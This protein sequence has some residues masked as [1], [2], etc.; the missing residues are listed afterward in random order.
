M[1]FSYQ[2]TDDQLSNVAIVTITVTPVN[3]PPVAVD[4]GSTVDEGGVFDSVVN[5]LTVF[6][7]ADSGLDNDTDPED[8]L[9]SA[10]PADGPAHGILDL[11]DNGTFTYTHDGGETVSDSFTY[12]ANDGECD[13]DA[14]ATVNITIN[15]V[16]DPPIAVD[17]G[18]SG[19]YA[20]D[21]NTVLEIPGGGAAVAGIGHGYGANYIIDVWIDS[22]YGFVG[23]DQIVATD[24]GHFS[25]DD[26]RGASVAGEGTTDVYFTSFDFTLGGVTWDSNTCQNGNQPNGPVSCTARINDYSGEVLSLEYEDL[27]DGYILYLGRSEQPGEA[28]HF[29][30]YPYYSEFASTEGDSPVTEG[31]YWWRKAY[32]YGIDAFVD[33][34]NGESAGETGL[35]SGAGGFSLDES[36]AASVEGTNETSIVWISSF[37]FTLGDVTWDQH[38]YFPNEDH[39]APFALVDL[40][41]QEILGIEIWANEGGPPNTLGGYGGGTFLIISL[42]GSFRIGN[43][44]ERPLEASVLSA[45]P[46]GPGGGA[47][48]LV[49]GGVA[50][51]STEVTGVL[52][53]DFD[54]ENDLL[55]VNVGLTDTE[56]ALGAYVDVNTDGSFEYDPTVSDTLQGLSDGE[57]RVDTFTYWINDPSGESDSATVSIMVSGISDPPELTAIPDQIRA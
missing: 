11:M 29:E 31:Y 18:P 4:D 16:N 13:S 54:A 9:L 6:A 27:A 37:S 48:P 42:D 46:S 14:T 34:D 32:D 43:Q 53:N 33:S 36:D 44:G 12:Y 57:S 35:F 1:S 40:V 30:I 49:S 52:D 55:V 15:P 25:V 26:Y 3:D 21:E 7:G 50:L 47:D 24:V 10:V 45:E 39:S 22:D 28:D 51:T 38:S 5:P 17:D 2:A 19:D 20:A 56:S 23:A 41:T 8:D